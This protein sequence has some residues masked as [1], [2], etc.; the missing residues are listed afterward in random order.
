MGLGRK[1]RTHPTTVLIRITDGRTDGVC[2]RS[3][4]EGIGTG[5]V[6]KVVDLTLTPNRG[7]AIVTSKASRSSTVFKVRGCLDDTTRWEGQGNIRQ[8]ITTLFLFSEMDLLL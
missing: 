5:D 1:L 3:R 6:V 8:G 4:N 2:L 7:M